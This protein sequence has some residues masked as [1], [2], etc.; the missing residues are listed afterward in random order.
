MKR[1]F[2]LH[3]RWRKLTPDLDHM[4][5]T[6]PQ[7]HKWVKF[8]IFRQSY[9]LTS[10]SHDLWHSIVTFDL[11]NM[12]RLLLYINKP[13]LVPVGFQ[14]F[15]WG[16]FYIFSPSYNL[17]FDDLC[18]RYMTLDHMN[19]HRVPSMNQVWFQSDFQLFK[20]GDCHIFS[21]F[22]NLTS[23]DLWPWYETF[24]L[25]NKWGS[26]CYIHNP[27]LVEIHQSMKKLE[28]NVKGVLHP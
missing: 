7:V 25:I 12:W 3:F 20:W 27:T 6:G 11:M 23:N 9:K 19:I 2:L 13:S 21:L 16:E 4:V 17:T 1:A 22:Y 10:T 15:K 18:P 28:P 14:L 26:P 24:N 8:Y 5:L